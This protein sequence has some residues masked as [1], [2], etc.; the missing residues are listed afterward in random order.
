MIPSANGLRLL[1]SH[2]FDRLAL[3]PADPLLALIGEFARDTRADKIDIGVGVY[4]DASGATPVFRA[5]KAAER[6]LV[7]CQTTKAYVGPEGNVEFLDRLAPIVFGPHLSSLQM[8]AVQT[9]GGTGALRLSAELIAT[10]RPCARVFVGNPTWPNHIPIMRAAGLELV[11]TP[12]F[13]ADSGIIAFEAMIAALEDARPGDVLLLHG[14][15]HNPTGTDLDKAQ[16]HRVGALLADRGVLPLIDLAYQGLGAG[17]EQDAAGMRIVL[18]AVDEALIAYSCDKNF[19][20]YRER[21]GA[22]FAV[23]H[24]SA[25]ALVVQSHLLAL[26]RANWSM[27]PDHGAAVVATILAEPQLDADWRAEL[28]TMQRRIAEVRETL[29]REGPALAPLRDGYGMFAMLPLTSDQVELMR[30]RY[31][32]YMPRSGR[33]NLAGL[34]PTTIDPFLAAFRSIRDEERGESS[35]VN[36]V[37]HQIGVSK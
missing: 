37:R 14:C 5:V 28:D 32:I 6:R 9:P 24:T 18:Q 35:H 1:E 29:A 34:E 27:P 11:E 17:L 19:G 8:S 23:S 7:E 25:D 3:Q 16:W 2:K 26:S 21:T 30:A 20:L 15:C 31:G 33:I 12:Y 22:L 4:R 13:D 10:A 36:Q